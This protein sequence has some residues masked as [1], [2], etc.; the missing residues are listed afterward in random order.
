MRTKKFIKN[1]KSNEKTSVF[2]IKNNEYLKKNNKITKKNK[3]EL[4]SDD[5]D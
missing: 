5:E 3:F 2:N 1:I 4:L